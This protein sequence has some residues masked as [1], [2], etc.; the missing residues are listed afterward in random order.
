[1]FHKVSFIFKLISSLAK[2]KARNRKAGS[3]GKY[4]RDRVNN[5]NQK[6]KQETKGEF[7]HPD[8]I[9]SLAMN[10]SRSICVTGSNGREPF[11]FVWDTQTAGTQKK[12]LFQL[13]RGSRS[14]SA[15][16]IGQDKYIYAADMSDNHMIHLYNVDGKRNKKG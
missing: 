7:G 14:I 4:N 2:T 9:R 13:P 10:E 5:S 15:V 16:A 6:R 11:V 1:M 12:E 3:G 8:D